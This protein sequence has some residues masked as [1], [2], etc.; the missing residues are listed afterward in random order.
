MS[1]RLADIYMAIRVLEH[2]VKEA[3]KDLSAELDEL[4]EELGLDKA[5]FRTPY[6]LLVGTTVEATIEYHEDDRMVAYAREHYPHEVIEAWEE[7]V[8]AYVIE[9]PASVRETLAKT[10]DGRVIVI[11]GRVIDK[12]TGEE[13]SFARYVPAKKGW[14]ARITNDAKKAVTAGLKAQMSEAISLVTKEI[15]S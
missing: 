11:D 15:E 6:G 2:A 13:L 8:P 12:E 1:D 4:R 5:N 9:H 10:L 7:E 14:S 3:G